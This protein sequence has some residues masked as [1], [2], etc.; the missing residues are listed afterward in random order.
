M[1]LICLIAVALAGQEDAQ[2]SIKVTLDRLF[3]GYQASVVVVTDENTAK[4]RVGKGPLSEVLGAT[5][6][7]ERQ[8][9]TPF[10]SGLLIEPRPTLDAETASRVLVAGFRS[11][12]KD[13][14]AQLSAGGIFAGE[15]PNSTRMAAADLFAKRPEISAALRN[16]ESVISAIPLVEVTDVADPSRKF[17]FT[18]VSPRL[19]EEELNRMQADKRF[20]VP[21]PT[22]SADG[23]NFEKGM[24]MT[25]GAWLKEI[26]TGLK[27]SYVADPKLLNLSLYIRG[28]FN[29]KQVVEVLEELSKCES[30]TSVS[31]DAEQPD[32]LGIDAQK[33]SGLS[34]TELAGLQGK[35]FSEQELAQKFPW[36]LVKGLRSGRY[37]A[38]VSLQLKA[39]SSSAVNSRTLVDGVEQVGTFLTVTSVRVKF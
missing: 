17:Y 32:D 36:A 3:S 8:K 31:H 13:R 28:R 10:T 6:E 22:P 20:S 4:W 29:H 37:T 25:L 2:S 35:D 27:R 9:V 23:V 30:A 12:S 34:P 26:R 14:R 1:R 19:S 7:G 16:G 39:S 18:A 33:Y 24:L 11:L 5:I 38:K 21:V 15:L